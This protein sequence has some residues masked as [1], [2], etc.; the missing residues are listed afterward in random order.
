[1]TEI[2]G[3][4]NQSQM[5]QP[6]SPPIL[7]RAVDP[8]QYIVGP[9]DFFSIVLGGQPVEEEHQL[10]VSPEGFLFIPNIGEVEIAKLTLSEAKRRIGEIIKEKYIAVNAIIHL[11]QLRS[12]RVTV[13][14]AV[15]N[16]GLVIVN[17]LDRVS[18]AIQLAEGLVLEDT[19]EMDQQEAVTVATEKQS[20]REQR[21]SIE[22]EEKKE[23][24]EEKPASLRNI[25]VKRYDGTT[26]KADF[27]RFQLNGDP[28]ANPYLIDGDVIIVPSKQKDAGQLWIHGA[29]KTPGKFE[30]VR[31]DKVGNI[32]AM[33]HGF[34]A[35]ADSSM[36]ELIR[37]EGATLKTVKTMYSLVTENPVQR[38][39]VLD[40]A[41]E[42]D[43]R[44]FVRSL[45]KYHFKANVE[46]EGE[47]HYPGI[48]AIEHG[49]TRL[50][51][52]VKI[53]G[54]FTDLASL[55]NA[56][57]VRRAV[58]EVRDPELE[59][60]K[61]MEV[62]DM[63]PME[64]D[65]YKVKL[66]ERVGGMGVDFRALFEDSDM[67]QDVILKDN[68]LIVVPERELTVNITGQVINPGLFPYQ[69][70]HSLSY[71]IEEAGGYNWNARKS[72]VRIIKARTGEWM[73]HGRKTQI[74]VGDTIFVPERPEVDW[75]TLATEIITIAA[76][77]AT[78][79]LVIERATEK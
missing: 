55:K 6:L 76:Q 23:E 8:D 45:P 32:L 31:G 54:G 58:E 65:Y 27:L 44:I 33:A 74:E 3:M 49:V 4:I 66:R 25:V 46:I 20:K 63:T 40:T 12:F 71:Y 24:E 13:S 47:V 22:F 10:M 29:V 11:L 18:D 70:A 77:L 61:Q 75:W 17:A 41:L 39:K 73:K 34:A 52:F 2:Q 14:G 64:R 1:M 38:Q 57:I 51:E 68:D 78:V 56:Y 21:Q 50:S 67:T 48:Y 53:A 42:P 9:G 43:D 37:F 28:D 62:A 35:D 26:I 30:Y 7:D 59:R 19:E 5:A 72:K 16:P 69:S 60:L 15:V 36:I 79:Y